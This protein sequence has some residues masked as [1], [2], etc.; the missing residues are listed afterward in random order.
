MEYISTRGGDRRL[1]F[2]EAVLTGQARDGGLLLPA[3]TPDVR[4]RLRE[5]SRLAY[6]DLAFEIMR[7]YADDLPAATL[8]ALVEGGCA[9]FRQPE[10]APVVPVDGLHVLELF[11]GPTLAFKDV[12]LQFMGRLLEELLAEG[13]GELNILAATS[14]DT[15]SAAIEGVRGRRRMRIFVLHPRG[16][17]SRIQMLQ[18]TTVADDNVHNLAVDG[19]F[20]DCQ[21]IVKSLFAD[22]AF[23]DRCRLGAVNSINWARL[24]AQMVY[25]FHAAFRVME[26]TGAGRVDFCVPTGNFG[27]VLAGY[28]AWR[29]GLPVGRLL[30]ATNAND[31]LARCLA[32]GRYRRGA[33]VPTLSPSMDIQVASNFERYLHYRAGGDPAR[34]QEWMERFRREGEVALTAGGAPLDDPVLRGGSADDE[35]ILATI[36]AWW[37][38]HRYLLDP[39]T[40]AGVH[41]AERNLEPGVPMICL[42]TA[43]PAKFPEAVRRATGADLARHPLLDALE[44]R[45][46]RAVRLPASRE[47]VAGHLARV[48]VGPQAA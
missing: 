17:V 28:L 25:Y 39:H 3:E 4:G 21:E 22:L 12:A 7:L 14:G 11:H 31:I 44:G 20:D 40:A 30:L 16:R 6:R 9:A 38:R 41:V 8:R 45:P 2:R 24:L 5:W 37:E 19:T 42:A 48:I 36:R 29:M 13:G 47:A 27:N 1:R 18:M 35:A 43:H 46:V 15:G 10:V 23:R 26:R 33:V 32:D 34:V